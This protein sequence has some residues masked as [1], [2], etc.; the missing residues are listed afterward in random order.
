MAVVLL[1]SSCLCTGL[2][3]HSDQIRWYGENAGFL[4][5]LNEAR[6]FWLRW[7]EPLRLLKI[8]HVA[9]AKKVEISFCSQLCYAA[10]ANHVKGPPSSD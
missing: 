4:I 9:A 5:H 3:L 7:S 2:R 6:P 8:T 10:A 1:F